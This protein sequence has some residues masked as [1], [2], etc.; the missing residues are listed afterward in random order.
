MNKRLLLAS[1]IATVALSLAVFGCKGKVEKPAEEQTMET[2]ESTAPVSDAQTSA[3]AVV[4]PAQSVAAETIPPTAAAPQLAEKPLAVVTQVA[5][6][7]N[8]E[9]Q[10]ALKNAGFYT[11]AIDG[12]LG[13]RTKKAILD[14]QNA[15]GL[16]ADGKVGPK[17]WTALEKYLVKQ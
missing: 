10:A 14:F 8:K 1:V 7:K 9:I 16:K 6:D 17:T 4:E 15:N 5:Q 2:A 12:K 11:G 13:P 3:Q